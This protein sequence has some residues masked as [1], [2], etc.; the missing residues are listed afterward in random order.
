MGHMVVMMPNTLSR[1]FDSIDKLADEGSAR[2]GDCAVLKAFY[3]TGWQDGFVAGPLNLLARSLGI[4]ETRLMASISALG[5]I[6]ALELHT[7]PCGEVSVELLSLSRPW[8][9]GDAGLGWWQYV[10]VEDD[11]EG[12]I[13][14]DSE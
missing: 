11:A 1:A 8:L 12:P 4:S 7:L 5:K 10:L 14:G 9:T 3:A 13:T 6:Q 2:P